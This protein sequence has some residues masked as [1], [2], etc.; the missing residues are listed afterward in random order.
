MHFLPCTYFLNEFVRVRFYPQLVMPIPYCFF[1]F[2]T[3]DVFILQG[4][5]R[6]LPLESASMFF[7]DPTQCISFYSITRPG[8]LFTFVLPLGR[9]VL[10]A[11]PIPFFLSL[12]H[13][14]SPGQWQVTIRVY[15]IVRLLWNR[16]S[17]SLLDILLPNTSCRFPL[18]CPVWPS[19]Y[20]IFPQDFHLIVRASVLKKAIPRTSVIFHHE[21][22]S[23]SKVL[24]LL[25]ISQ[26]LPKYHLMSLVT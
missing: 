24:S 18:R 4:R 12:C 17:V 25:A 15:T 11:N 7:W 9:S 5:A 6:M 2:F 19:P 8:L 21:S 20:P 13:E 16:I 26:T 22:Q 14:T 1:F 3:V 10:R 23:S